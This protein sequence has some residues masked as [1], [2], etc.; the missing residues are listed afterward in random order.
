MRAPVSVGVN[1]VNGAF[2]CVG[3]NIC[4][5]LLVEQGYIFNQLVG[6]L[7]QKLFLTSWRMIAK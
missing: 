4:F 5:R 1:E 2:W 7:D 3:M 6:R